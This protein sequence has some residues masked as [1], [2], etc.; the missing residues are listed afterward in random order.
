MK[1]TQKLIIGI[2][3]SIVIVF[4]G[5]LVSWFIFFGEQPKYPDLTISNY[6]LE[7]DNLTV[8]ITNIGD[9]DASTV[10]IIVQIDA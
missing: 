9:S 5:V 7:N 1:K 8:S 10:I 2:V 4:S 3:L 6:S